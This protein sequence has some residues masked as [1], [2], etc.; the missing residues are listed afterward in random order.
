MTEHEEIYQDVAGEMGESI[1]DI[2]TSSAIEPACVEDG[3]YKIRITGFKK[4]NDGK[5]VR[6]KSETGNKFF[7][8]NFDIPTEAASK[9]FSKIFSVPVEG[10][11]AKRLNGV[12]WDLE[13]LKR[14][15]N[16]TELN[17]NEMVG[18]EGYAILRKTS[19]EQYG[20]QNDVVKFIIGA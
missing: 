10:M 3:E 4:D 18:K 6:T 20:E 1:L 17:F 2:D 7:I 16:L 13:C 19:S 15:F 8:V 14:A 12:K 5:I 9:N 11:D